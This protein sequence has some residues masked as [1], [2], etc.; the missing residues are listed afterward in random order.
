MKRRGYNIL[1]AR[2]TREGVRFSP[3]S[4][5]DFR[6]ISAMLVRDCL[7][8]HTYQLPE[9]KLLNVVIRDV[10]VGVAEQRVGDALAEMG[11]HP[12]GVIRMKSRRTE[13][14]ISLILV[15]IGKEHKKKL[16]EGVIWT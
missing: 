5:T 8:Y 9:E 1:K 12:E 10:P 7:P 13:V 14:T 2:S 3:A 15:K 4:V 16:S 6:A 11:F